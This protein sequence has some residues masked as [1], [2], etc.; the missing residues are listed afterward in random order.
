MLT[1]TRYL[2]NSSHYLGELFY[3]ARWFTPAVTLA[4]YAGLIVLALIPRNRVM[5]FAAISLLVTP[6]PVSFISIRSAYVPYLPM[7][8][9]ALYIA[10]LIA[11]LRRKL[12]PRSAGRR[13]VLSMQIAVFVVCLF[14]LITVHKSGRRHVDTNGIGRPFVPT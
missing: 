12:T 8:G 7:A 4:L 1:V 3:H 2:T 10:V 5:T 6:L 14:L 9:W 11:T 13:S